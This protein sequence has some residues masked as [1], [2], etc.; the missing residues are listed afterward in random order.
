MLYQKLFTLDPTKMWFL[1]C[2]IGCTSEIS[3]V[4]KV[5]Q[6]QNSSPCKNQF[7]SLIYRLE[8][9]VIHEI[10]SSDFTLCCNSKPM[11]YTLPDQPTFLKRPKNA[12]ADIDE[13]VYLFCEVDA[14]P[15]SEIIWVFDPIDRV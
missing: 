13:T 15:P 1:L 3:I 9:Y 11:I 2:Y 8:M 12:E 14:N 6:S 7:D 4:H 5:H 10:I